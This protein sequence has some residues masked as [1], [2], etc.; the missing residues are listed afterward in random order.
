ME[1]D[2]ASAEA[3]L[4]KHFGHSKFR[5][6]QVDCLRSIYSRSDTVTLMATGAGKSLLYQFPS[7]LF[8][9]T[10]KRKSTTLVV[11]PLISLMADQAM[12]LRQ[13]TC[14][15]CF[16]NSAQFAFNGSG[17]DFGGIDDICCL[18]QFLFSFCQ[19]G[20]KLTKVCFHGT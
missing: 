13:T 15:A 11:S 10:Y 12:H 3:C 7:L 8:E 1:L 5:P 2:L 18:N 4:K 9:E 16:L 17:F 20:A 14:R 6:L 19:N